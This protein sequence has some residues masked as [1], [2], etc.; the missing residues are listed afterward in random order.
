MRIQAA[1]LLAG[2]QLRFVADEDAAESEVNCAG[3]HAPCCRARHLNA[4]PLSLEEAQVLPHTFGVVRFVNGT[5]VENAALLARHPVTKECAFITPEGKC[6]IWAIRPKACRV[7]S[8]LTD[9]NAEMERFVGQR[10]GN[11]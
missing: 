11:R 8:C 2:V 9:E 5:T 7:Y 6:S 1:Q 3:C 4:V 10:F